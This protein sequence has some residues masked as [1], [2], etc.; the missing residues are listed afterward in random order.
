MVPGVAELAHLVPHPR[1]AL[2]IEAG[3]R[4][5]EEEQLGQVHEPDADVEAALLPARIGLGRSVGAV[6]ELERRDE[7]RRRAATARAFVI[8]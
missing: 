5:V 1:S 4:L 8:P 6:V 3:G 7:L 2:R